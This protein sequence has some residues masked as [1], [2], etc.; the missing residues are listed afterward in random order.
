MNER[1]YLRHADVLATMDDAQQEIRDGA[2]LTDGPR[3]LQVG[4]TTALD[5]WIAQHPELW[6]DIP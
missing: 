2:L 3:I 1:L 4:S 6:K 5:A